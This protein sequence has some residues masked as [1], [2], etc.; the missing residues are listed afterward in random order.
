MDNVKCDTCKKDFKEG[1]TSHRFSNKSDYNDYWSC[2][3]G[4]NGAVK[5]TE[6][7]EWA[8]CFNCMPKEQVINNFD[9]RHAV[10]YDNINIG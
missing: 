3:I 10:I 4:E 5:T 7:S 1:K 9:M 6:F 8:I 2:N